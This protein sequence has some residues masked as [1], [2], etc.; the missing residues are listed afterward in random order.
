[1][2]SSPPS[3]QPHVSAEARSVL[4]D[5]GI[6][7]AVERLSITHG[8]CLTCAQ[9][10][11][12]SPVALDAI[13][14]S[15]DGLVAVLLRH[16]ECPEPESIQ[17]TYCTTPFAL[18]ETPFTMVHPALESLWL[19]SVRRRRFGTAR[20]WVDT[21]AGAFTELGLV[22][23]ASNRHG[24]ILPDPAEPVPDAG[25]RF[26]ANGAEI[27]LPSYGR[28]AVPMDGHVKTL[29]QQA[30]GSY[31]IVSTLSDHSGDLHTEVNRVLHSNEYVIGWVPVTDKQV[32]TRDTA[33]TLNHPILQNQITSPVLCRT[34]FADDP[35]LGQDL[36]IINTGGVRTAGVDTDRWP[37]AQFE[38]IHG[39]IEQT[40][41]RHPM[42]ER[43][44]A[45]GLPRLNWSS[46]Q[47][48]YEVDG[49]HVH[50]HSDGRMELYGPDG[51]AYASGE[52][53]PQPDWISA[54]VGHGRVLVQ[55]GPLLGIRD[56]DTPDQSRTE[57]DRAGAAGLVLGG[58]VPFHRN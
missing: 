45:R 55:L 17:L 44:A 31:V 2:G 35:A 36:S 58:I 57:L 38:Q 41:G 19:T 24:L 47:L 25:I 34:T 49:W 56:C 32:L 1:M 16:T 54:A 21:T 9:P 3:E 53:H 37:V 7:V 50:H 27:D 20:R 40:T 29:V 22:P 5:A 23:G 15:S 48:T 11:A 42:L 13:H 10:L 30:G 8:D 6:A 33:V 12:D 18:G 14:R 26:I 4:G 28:W 52:A 46:G 39:M 43:L 51:G